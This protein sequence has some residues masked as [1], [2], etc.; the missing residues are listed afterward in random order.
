MSAHN[1]TDDN[2]V[3]TY[4][5]PTDD[6]QESQDNAGS[7]DNFHQFSADISAEKKTLWARIQKKLKDVLGMR[8]DGLWFHQTE[9][10]EINEESLVVGVPNMVVQ[11]HLEQRYTEPLTDVAED[12]LDR[13]VS[14]RFRVASKLFKEMK[15]RQKKAAE[16]AEG[17]RPALDFTP[18]TPE[19]AGEE[20]FR[21]LV[22]TSSNRLPMA[23]AREIA[24]EQDT[25]VTFLLLWGGHGTGKSVLLKTIADSAE[26][27]GHFSCVRRL[28]AER[29]CNAY[30]GAVRDQN[31]K[32]FKRRY[33]GCDFLIIDDLHFLEGKPAAQEELVHTMKR[34]L[35]N[36]AR[37]ALGSTVTPDDMD[38]VKPSLQ[39]FLQEALWA[40]LRPPAP[41]ERED[42]VRQ[43]ARKQDLE[44]TPQV[45]RYIARGKHKTLR[46]LCSTVSSLATYAHLNGS[47]K[48]NMQQATEA[49]S[50]MSGPTPRRISLD[51]ISR[52]AAEVLS[53]QHKR[54]LGRTQSRRACH[55]RHLAMYL[56]RQMT[57][58]SL[59]EIGE[60]FGGRSHSTVKHAV[61][62]VDEMAGSD[63]RVQG[64]LDAVKNTL[65]G[66]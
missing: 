36:N 24:M 26:E 62:K 47:G 65:K 59:S 13:T 3:E 2:E 18:D 30:Y 9:L 43:M 29:W 14:V 33:R 10:M 37:V 44:A 51:S 45:L 19:S 32:S 61:D 1:D 27:S 34:L 28:T 40:R 5:T 22:Q 25:R 23:A 35:N 53:V 6:V 46:D 39:T 31:T 7:K 15:D 63:N 49:L 60:H 64:E 52:S 42:V 57:D 48:L 8:R 50:H 56:A 58:H 55:A 54:V 20:P 66:A 16:E 41:D 4:G 11:Q 21:N 17:T 12:V 38:E